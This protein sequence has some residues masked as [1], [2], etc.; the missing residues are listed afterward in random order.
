MPPVGDDMLRDEGDDKNEGA[1]P[2][3]LAPAPATALAPDP[4]AAVA[5]EALLCICAADENAASALLIAAPSIGRGSV[6]AE[7]P[8]RPAN[9]GCN[10]HVV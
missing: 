8:G 1:A 2:P 7:T 3:A 9:T 4:A 6:A 10:R 5:A